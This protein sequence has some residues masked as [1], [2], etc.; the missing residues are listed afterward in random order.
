MPSLELKRT[1]YSVAPPLNNIV[2]FIVRVVSVALA[3]SSSTAIAAPTTDLWGYWATHDSTSPATVD[4][5]SWQQLLDRHVVRNADGINRVRYQSF[6][7]SDTSQLN[8]YI[9]HLA[10]ITPTALSREQQLPYWINL[11]NALTVRVVLQH[12]TKDSIRDMK[13]RLFSLGPW[14]DELLTIE[15]QAVTLNDIEHR[16]L[17][18]IWQDLRLHYVLNC[19]SLGCPNLSTTAYTANNTP[20]QLHDAE[21]IF[22]R[23]ARAIHFTDAG[24]LKLSSLFD[25]YQT[26]F[27]ADTAA[28]LR[29][30][31]S[32]RADLADQLINYRGSIDYHYDWS[33]NRQQGVRD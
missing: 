19:A 27:G 5:Q 28:V 8:A 14:D 6:T 11:Y 17:R 7:A 22:L 32:Q 10:A 33:L 12:P 9:D 31:A 16:I 21:E 15:N 13:S 29:Y 4:H 3:L 18:P 24:K 2:L 1:Y 30:L 23:H 25:W 26:D 20:R